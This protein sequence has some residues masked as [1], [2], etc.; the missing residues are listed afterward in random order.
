MILEA[1]NS[2][3]SDGDATRH[4]EMV[5]ISR[6]WQLLDQATRATC[7]L[8]AST[9]PCL[10]CSGAILWAGLRKVV[11]GV[12]ARRMSDAIKQRYEGIPLTELA[13]LAGWEMQVV[14]PVMQ[15]DGLQIHT[16]FWPAAPGQD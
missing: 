9:E 2:V 7:T 8:Y 12:G 4:A 11:F 6:A 14:G 15:D 10:M 1:E 3:T 5:L 16:A 13:Q